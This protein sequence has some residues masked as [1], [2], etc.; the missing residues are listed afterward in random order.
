V[1]LGIDIRIH[2]YPVVEGLG[3]DQDATCDPTE[4]RR[5][6]ALIAGYPAQKPL[7]FMAFVAWSLDLYLY[8]L[9]TQGVSARVAFPLGLYRLPHPG[10]FA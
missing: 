5:M 8:A 7:S 1:P 9:S 10:R 4:L 2:P 3:V 6:N